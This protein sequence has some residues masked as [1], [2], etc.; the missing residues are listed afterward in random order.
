[1]NYIIVDLEATC[2]E[3]RSDG[4][5]EI[6]EIGAVKVNDDQEIVSEYQQFVKPL[7]NPILSEFCKELTSIQQTDVENAP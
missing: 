4:K 1:M 5:N 2:W 6:I 3:N 7:K